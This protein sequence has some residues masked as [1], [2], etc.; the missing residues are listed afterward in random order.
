M[1]ALVISMDNEAQCVIDNMQDA[2]ETKEYGRRVVRG[3]VNGEPV[4]LVVSGLGKANA[5]AATQM[6]I[7]EGADTVINLGVAGGLMPDIEVADI[8]E[9]ESAVQYDFD[10]SAVT[11]NMVG[12]LDERETPY[13]PLNLTGKYP[14]MLIG[15]GD[16]FND[17]DT[18]NDLLL[19]VLACQ[20]RDM[21]CAAVAQVCERANVSCY[22]F[23]CVTDVRGKGA[24]TGQYV[25]NLQRCL[26]KLREQVPALLAAI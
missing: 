6:V 18:D 25:D 16:R 9:V 3:T 13:I 8:Y 10:L 23:K 2:Q 20:L 17:S 24:M 5:A 1:K 22:A 12:T 19:N 26:D 7:Q 15:S 21:E 11:G 4:L 14:T